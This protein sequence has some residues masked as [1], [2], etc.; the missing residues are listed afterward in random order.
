M[1][2]LKSRLAA[3]SGNL[4]GALWMTAA[5]LVF[6]VMNGLIR[7]VGQSLHGFEVAFLRAVFGCVYLLPV[8]IAAGGPKILRTAVPG[9]HAWRAAFGG[10]T[11]LLSFYAFT[12][13]PLAESTT[14]S[15][16]APLFMLILA[17]AVLGE[18]VGWHRRIAAGV[19]FVGV[20]I[21]TRPGLDGVS[22]ASAAMLLSAFTM[23][24]GMVCVKALA[25]TETPLSILVIFS[26]A[27]VFIDA[28]PAAL[29]WRTPTFAETLWMLVIA[30]LGTLGQYLYIRAYRAGEASLVAPFNFLQLPFAVGIGALLFG[31]APGL[32]TLAGG[33][34]IVASGLYIMQRESA[35]RRRA[36]AASEPL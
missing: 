8:V 26:V 1:P 24:C 17:Q 36:A 12:R 29:V 25:R 20:L 32:S 19:G 27:V 5:A 21:A 35:A 13:L 16:S 33:L 34:I 2:S 18:T 3:A 10:A 30:G 7:M 11:M 4:R 23:A 15:F 14:I 28:I 31:E 22:A 6:A 9:L